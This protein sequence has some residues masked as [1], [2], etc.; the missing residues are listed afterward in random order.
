MAHALRPQLE[1]IIQGSVN[2]S[3]KGLLHKIFGRPAGRGL[4]GFLQVIVYLRSDTGR[5][6]MMSPHK[7]A[8]RRGR[9][10][11]YPLDLVICRAVLKPSLN[12]RFLR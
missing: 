7:K 8:L 12:T 1:A 11:V 6:F 4:Y 3:S 2:S 10:T 5:S 9:V